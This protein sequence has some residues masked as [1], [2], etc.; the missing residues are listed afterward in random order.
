MLL[1]DGTGR[2]FF[3]ARNYHNSTNTGVRNYMGSNERKSY[4]KAVKCMFSSPSKSDP[5]KVPGAR[6]RYDD[7]VAQHIN[8]TMS[9]HG[10]G[11]FLTWHRYFVWGY[12]KALRE[13]CGYKVS[14]NS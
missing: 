10:T 6:N 7:F 4:I 8:Q 13:E 14:E 11:N 2:V 3:L 1:F 12:E 9:I 5:A